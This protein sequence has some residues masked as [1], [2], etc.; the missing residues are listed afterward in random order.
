MV[1][2]LMFHPSM[3]LD[4]SESNQ[5]YLVVSWVVP[6]RQGGMDFTGAHSIW[7]CMVMPSQ[8]SV[9]DTCKCFFECTAGNHGQGRNFISSE[10]ALSKF[11]QVW[12]QK[13]WRSMCILSQV[14]RTKSFELII[15]TGCKCFKGSVKEFTLSSLPLS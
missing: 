8:V 1:Q 4:M 14:K 12:K 9:D 13:F 2:D 11:I 5:F 15:C 3:L 10:F 7:K 6:S